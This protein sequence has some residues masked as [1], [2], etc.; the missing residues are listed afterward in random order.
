MR[1][2]M[3]N[4]PWVGFD[5]DGTLAVYDKWEGPEHIGPPI[6]SMVQLV[7]EKLALGLTVKIFTARVCSTQP[8][9][10]IEKAQEAIKKWTKKYI[11]QEL[12]A[13]SEK[14]WYMLEY[15][16]DRAVQVKYNTGEIV[17]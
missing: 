1:F 4:K 10:Y 9:D 2:F 7:K 12:E 13:V 17:E 3:G 8:D 5:L 6:W 14:D 11:G 16:D 15:Y